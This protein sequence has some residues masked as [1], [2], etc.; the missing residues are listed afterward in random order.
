MVQEKLW[1]RKEISRKLEEIFEAADVSGDGVLS[2]EEFKDLLSIPSVKCYLELL[3]LEVREVQSLFNMLANGNGEIEYDE[4]VDG[5]MMLKGQA[6]AMD[7]ISLM[8]DVRRLLH[9]IG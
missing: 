1:E 8:L 4:F 6:R 2:L 9:R 3:E 7:M 5:I